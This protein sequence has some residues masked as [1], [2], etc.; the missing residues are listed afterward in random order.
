MTGIAAIIIA[1]G[2][3]TRLRPLTLTTP[4]SMLA[5]AGRPFISHLIAQYS[6]AGAQTVVLAASAPN[7]IYDRH[8]AGRR[9]LGI[10]VEVKFESR[11]MGT[12][13]AVVNAAQLT[14]G[15]TLIV[16]NGDNFTA[17]DFGL[18]L[19]QHQATQADVSIAVAQ[20]TEIQSYGSVEFDS[21]RKISK[22][23]EKQS[24]STSRWANVGTYI[25]NRSVIDSLPR[26][27]PLSMERDVFPR[28]I[29]QRAKV[30]AYKHYGYWTDLGTPARFVRG[31][32]DLVLGRVPSPLVEHPGESLAA[33]TAAVHRSA[34]LRDGT[35]IGEFA[36]IMS[37]VKLDRSVI[38]DRVTI[39]V[40]TTVSN[41]IVAE[42]ATIGAHCVLN[43]VV[44]GAAAT[45]SDWTI[46]Q[47]GDRVAP[48]ALV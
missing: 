25:F 23:E 28:L 41:S 33:R 14:Y 43:S 46:L 47:S 42:D 16:G 48:H 35:S 5:V 6:G 30:Y 11:P 10:D 45:V 21:D 32:T 12:G 37:Y 19:E 3:G 4:K 8:F 17:I 24:S 40:G 39:G 44:V 2:E 31:S 7:E 15:Q 13:G 34:I 9:F 22:F 27:M 18:M 1:G 20:T 29:S 26:N 38:F 36:E